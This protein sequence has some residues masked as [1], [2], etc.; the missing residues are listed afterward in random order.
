MA[1]YKHGN[2][3]SKYTRVTKAS[4]R[5][6]VVSSW[7]KTSTINRLAKRVTNFTTKL[8]GY[9]D[10]SSNTLPSTSIKQYICD[11]W[12]PQRRQ[13][14]QRQDEVSLAQMNKDI[15]AHIFD[16]LANDKDSIPAFLA[17][18]HTCR[19]FNN[20]LGNDEIWES[21]YP[22]YTAKEF[23]YNTTPRERVFI[24]R[25]LSNVRRWQYRHKNKKTTNILLDYI[26]GADGMRRVISLILER[27]N[28]NIEEEEASSVPVLRGDTIHY[29]A[30]VVQEYMINKIGRA[31][32]MAIQFPGSEG[33]YPKIEL[34]HLRSVDICRLSIDCRL[35]CRGLNIHNDSD[36]MN[37]THCSVSNGY[38]VCF[39]GVDGINFRRSTWQ[40]KICTEQQIVE[41]KN[42]DK[43][44]RALAYRAG[45]IQLSGEAFTTLETEIMHH[46]AVVAR[47][48]FLACSYELSDT[49]DYDD[50]GMEAL[51]ND[52]FA[53]Y[54][55]PRQLDSDGK[56]KCI[57][58]PRHIKGAAERSGM[59]SVIG[60]G[61]FGAMWAPSKDRTKEE[62]IDEAKAQYFLEDNI[63]MSNEYSE[64]EDDT[65]GHYYDDGTSI[66][67][68]SSVS[69]DSDESK[70][71][72]EDPSESEE[73]DDE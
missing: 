40:D 68:C 2:T 64:D 43:M 22:E 33:T 29:L 38:H 34:N 56:V 18:S 9:K 63:T 71:Y 73:S 14:Q 31:N 61:K 55:P 54:C 20:I 19:T 51:S 24:S 59:K 46:L 67:Y 66:S 45:A 42:M 23:D 12:V 32:M 27:T 58:I 15:I 47:S 28:A 49:T 35:L 37:F 65:G 52:Y 13:K 72:G 25:A 7:W 16:F 21:L 36:D 10:D 5:F 39:P 48:A 6:K 8:I 69:Y 11:N 44:V 17:L 4:P 26:G 57:I 62:E 53:N 41:A 50:E 3:G 70:S 60:C 1:P 30:E